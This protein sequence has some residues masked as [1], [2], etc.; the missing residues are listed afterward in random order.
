MLVGAVGGRV[1]RVGTFPAFYGR[2]VVLWG[3]PGGG[4][5]T[6]AEPGGSCLNSPKK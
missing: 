3:V 5:T 4:F 6:A 1:G 2:S